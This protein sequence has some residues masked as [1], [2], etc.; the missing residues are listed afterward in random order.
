M[1]H[2]N[3]FEQHQDQLGSKQSREEIKDDNGDDDD[4]NGDDDDGFELLGVM[5]GG[6][7]SALSPSAQ[8][9]LHALKVCMC[10]FVCVRIAAG[11]NQRIGIDTAS[12]QQKEQVEREGEKK[13]RKG[14]DAK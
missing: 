2:P 10:L 11:R 7:L 3:C 13:E 5:R 6:G 8:K 9:I 4:E 14:C 1:I 12:E